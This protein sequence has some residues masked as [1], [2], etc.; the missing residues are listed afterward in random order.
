MPPHFAKL[1]CESGGKEH[2][3]CDICFQ[4]VTPHGVLTSSILVWGAPVKGK[5]KEKI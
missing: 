5:T 2:C 3:T 4:Q 1:R